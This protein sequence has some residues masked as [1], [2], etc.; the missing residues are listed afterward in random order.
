MTNAPGTNA[1]GTITDGGAN[2]SSDASLKGTSGKRIDP[3]IDSLANNGGP[4]KTMAL[5]TGSPAI[6]AG[7]DSAAPDTD[8]RGVPRPIG[9]ASDIG[10]FELSTLPVILGQPQSQMQT[11]GG[12]VTFSVSAF[13]QGLTY[14]WRFYGSNSTPAKITGATGS[15]YTIPSIT[16]TNAGNYDVVIMNSFGSV[17]SHVASLFVGTPPVFTLVPTNQTIFSGSNA[18]FVATATNDSTLTYQWQFKGTNIAGATTTVLT[19]TNVQ[20][21]NNGTYTIIVSNASGFFVSASAVLTVDTSPRFSVSGHVFQN[22]VGISGVTVA[23]DTNSAVTDASGAYTIGGIHAGDYYVFATKSNLVFS[24]SVEVVVGPDASGINFSVIEP[25]Y[26]ISGRVLRGGVGFAGVD[27]FRGRTTDSNG[28]FQLS[29]SA[30]TYTL[31]PVAS[32]YSFSPANRTVTIPPAATNQDFIAGSKLSITERANGTV[33]LTLAGTGTTRLQ[34]STN[35]VDW[36]SIY[37]NKAPF[38]Y[39]NAIGPSDALLFYRAVQP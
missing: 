11:N 17:T 8:Q 18:V 7:D 12:P 33:V 22:G 31:L 20:V 21:A 1:Y 38:S 5:K 34:V 24:P 13:G 30:G 35:L 36:I 10:A 9:S 19:V 27:V 3:K 14:Q 23:V 15:S 26:N 25:T 37:T 16:P 4:T 2:I 29:L 32:G 39:T 28:F 6:D